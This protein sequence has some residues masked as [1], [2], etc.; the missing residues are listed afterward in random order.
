MR[1]KILGIGAV[2]LVGVLV[3]GI[4]AVLALPGTAQATDLARRGGG[5]APAD[6]VRSGRECGRGQHGRAERIGG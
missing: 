6:T 5:R 1:K 2:V 4:V 3:I